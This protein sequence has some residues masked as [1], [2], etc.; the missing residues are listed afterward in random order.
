MGAEAGTGQAP[1]PEQPSL[2]QLL[3]SLGGKSDGTL[4]SRG[5]V[6]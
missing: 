3:S 2:T 6:G 5:Q 1:A 4:M